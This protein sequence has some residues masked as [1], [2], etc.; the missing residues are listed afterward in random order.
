MWGAITSLFAG[1]VKPVVGY[2]KDKQDIHA[3]LQ[4]NKLKVLQAAGDRQA[5]LVS[6]GMAET[7]SWE[8][9]SMQ[10]GQDYRGLELIVLSIPVV[11]CFTPY[12]HI[13]DAGFR[14]LGHTPMWFQG[15]FITVYMANY[16]LRVSQTVSSMVRKAI[17]KKGS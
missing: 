11:M 3:Q 13:V 9:A 10:A 16:G 17:Q 15:I 7:A 6:Q 1:V 2:F 14:A 5:A 4:E 12:S 8:M